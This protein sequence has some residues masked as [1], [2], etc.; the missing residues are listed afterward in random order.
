VNEI[1]AV[2][3]GGEEFVLSGNGRVLISG[4]AGLIGSHIADLLVQQYNPE[5]IVLDNFVQGRRENLRWALTHGRVEIVDGDVR[6]GAL[7]HE[8]MSGIDF[9]F[10]N[11]A[12]PSAQCTEDPC[13]GMEV[14]TQ[15]TF[16]ILEAAALNRVK[17]VI[18]ASSASVY[19]LADDFPTSENHHS[20]NNRTLYG[21]AKAFNEAM[22]RSF[23]EMYGLNYVALRY[24]DVYGPRMDI[25][26]GYMEFL[27]RW[28]DRLAH[29]Q[30]CVIAGDGTQT[31][32][33]VYVD[34]IARA[35]IL[36][37]NADVT[38]EVFNIAS[39]VGTTLNELAAVL[40]RVMGSSVAPEYSIS[41]H[42]MSVPR[43]IGDPK[44]AEQMLSFRAG[45]PLEEGLHRL[46]AWWERQ[47]AL[48]AAI[49]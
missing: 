35:N 24:F 43:S 42:M 28:I 22:L 2:V 26:S 48:S 34:D 46:V 13:L 39:G 19:G 44:K 47:R 45:I 41:R 4:G 18:A 6:D 12:I 16:N 33:F 27:I 9:V 15:G 29:R 40:G 20:Y 10:H 37:V 7:I 3:G 8:L 31:M 36:A 1:Q 17:K 38:D 30:P 11:A 25:H 23:Y 32:D 49:A 21:A 5:I 14:L